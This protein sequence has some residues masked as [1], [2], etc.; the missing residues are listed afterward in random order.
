M[1]KLFKYYSRITFS[2]LI[3]FS[4]CLPL[5]VAGANGTHNKKTGF[6]AAPP[7]GNPG[8]RSEPSIIERFS[9]L[10]RVNEA[11][12]S[13]Y[14]RLYRF[15]D[16]WFGTPY[17]WSGC[18]K[19]GID[20]SCF[21]QKLYNQV[22]DIRI[23]RTS[24]M[25]F[26]KDVVLFTNRSQ[27]QL[28]DLVFFKTPIRRETRYNKVTHVGFYLTNGYFVQSSSKGVN[29]A[30]LNSGYW[31]NYFVAAGRLKD[32][33]YR[34]AR[35][36][37]P[38]G[39]VDN[40]RV[41]EVEEDSE[42]DPI[43]YPEDADSISNEYS[44]LLQVE[45]DLIIFPEVFQ[46]VEKNRYAP[47]NISSRCVKTVA[48]NSCFIS[49]F[50]NDVFT[51]GLENTDNRLFLSKYS[52]RLD[53]KNKDT[54]LDMVRLT[55]VKKGITNS[56]MGIY[57][58]NDYFLHLDKKDISISS[59]NDP[60]F[61]D[62]T[63]EFFRININLREKLIHNIREMRKNGGVLP[64]SGVYTVEPE[65]LPLKPVNILKTDSIPA[66]QPETPVMGP[67]PLP[68]IEQP[69]N[70]PD[71]KRITEPKKKRKKKKSR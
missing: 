29:I 6:H 14:M 15:I 49:T 50:F 5:T 36:V 17:L 43:L 10:V 13:R 42:F 27:F 11:E 64:D 26:C 71:P 51:L 47:Y 41:I 24:L 4:C 63:R 69:A 3:F 28:G 19:R 7:G 54:L 2:V 18:S 31:K 55:R 60:A 37:M 30:N 22:F 67:Q 9:K 45:K 48:D 59:L 1:Q 20:C 16:E 12:I 68:E 32:I 35:A 40:N 65:Q 70:T 34:K 33:Y 53:G 39:E 46:F 52:G 38:T 56:I 23:N 58:Y 8:N 44:R 57:L 62:Y 25:Q 21:V 61:S 66:P